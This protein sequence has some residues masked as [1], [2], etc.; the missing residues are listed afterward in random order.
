[1]MDSDLAT[2]RITME[3]NTKADVQLIK[4]AKAQK[5]DALAKIYDLYIKRVYRFVYF[6]VGNREDAEDITEQVF[7]KILSSIKNYEER[8]LPF[9]AWLFRIARNEIV[10]FYRKKHTGK[11]G[12]DEIGEIVDPTPSPQAKLEHK[13]EYKKVMRVLPKLPGQYQEIIVLKFMD[14]LEN[15]AISA[16]L[17]KPVDH[18]RVLQSRA[19]AKL[20]ELLGK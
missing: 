9:E 7:V 13:L 14:D 18:I 16:I 1:M 15:S 6:R 5:K 10:D 19:L 4:R 17:K 11:V 12:L 2:I 8:G 20:R 3:P